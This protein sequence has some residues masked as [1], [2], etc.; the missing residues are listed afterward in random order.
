MTRM[1]KGFTLIEL[2]TVLAVMVVLAAIV[3]MGYFGTTRGL[4][5]K[6]AGEHLAQSLNLARQCAI[7]QNKK[8]SVVFGQDASNSWYSICKIEGRITY[9]SGNYCGDEFGD[10]SG[11]T[12][13][14]I[15]NLDTAQTGMVQGV[16][17]DTISGVN[18]WI[19]LVFPDIFPGTGCEYA[20]ELYPRTL[21]PR[22]LQF[23]KNVST[24]ITQIIFNSTGAS[25]DKDGNHVPATIKI[26]EK[27]NF[28]LPSVDVNVNEAGFVR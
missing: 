5:A 16:K 7:M 15:Y 13:T 27:I 8:V 2:L 21:L 25:V 23:N 19:G 9:K 6:S 10:W 11:W 3:V 20:L 14:V 22:G 24:P 17:S 28:N 18:M 1:V 4:A 12:N 26:Y